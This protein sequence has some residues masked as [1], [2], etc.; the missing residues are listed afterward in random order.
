M[1]LLRLLEHRRI[2]ALRIELA[3]RLM[4]RGSTGPSR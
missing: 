2:E 4:E 3:T 1:L